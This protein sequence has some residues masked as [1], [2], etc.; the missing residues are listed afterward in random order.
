MTVL[1]LPEPE[2]HA[3]RLDPD[4]RTTLAPGDKEAGPQK[5]RLSLS[6]P[7]LTPL[8][9]KTV[10]A[11]A[12]PFLKAHPRSA[13][14]LLSLTASFTHIESDPFES[15]WVD[16]ALRCPA[17]EAAV[18]PVAWSMIP[19]SIE[20]AVSVSRTV[21]LGSD[22][23]F[24]HPVAGLGASFGAGKKETV[25]FTLRDVRVE[26]LKEGTRDP[27][28]EFWPTTSGTIRGMQTLCLVIDLP[29]DAHGTAS[30][31]IGAT[32]RLHRIKKVFRFKSALS[33][34]PEIRTVQIEPT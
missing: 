33:G 11:D 8:D 27:R 24:S 17:P 1:E 25:T 29:A 21:K 22:L 14:H 31:N 2:L 20:E 28:W 4:K 3:I 13:F 26:A 9:T 5:G 32:I 15:A 18:H 12:M 34:I 30:V 6:V 23:K 19:R 10:A 7:L 16:I